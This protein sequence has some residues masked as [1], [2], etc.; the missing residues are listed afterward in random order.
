MC[1]A[2]RLHDIL[3]G[4][5]RRERVSREQR[6]ACQHKFRQECLFLSQMR[7]PNIVQFMGIHCSNRDPY[8]ITLFM[9]QLPSDLEQCLTFCRGRKYILPISIKVSILVDVCSGLL[10]LHTNGIIHR[11][12][13]AANI[14]LTHDMQ[15]KIADLGVSKILSERAWS[16]KLTKVPGALAYMPPEALADSPDYDTKLDVFSFGVVALF[17]A[18]QEFPEFSWEQTPEDIYRRGE[19][20]LWARRKWIEKMGNDHP[21]CPLVHHCLLEKKRRITTVEIQYIL[22]ALCTQYPCHIEDCL[23]SLVQFNSMLSSE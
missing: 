4:A 15:A 14:L 10:H 1:I 17:M 6:Q 8:D 20:A 18:T 5:G 3:T 21:F 23:S 13:S 16:Q 19:S 9:E 11:D 22:E 7:H 12:L 2:K